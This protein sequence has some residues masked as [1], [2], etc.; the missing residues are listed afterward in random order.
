MYIEIGT[1]T[2]KFN[3]SQQ[4]SSK[5]SVSIFNQTTELES[6]AKSALRYSVHFVADIATNSCV[7]NGIL[8]HLAVTVG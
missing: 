2:G 6:L 4:I 3:G 8:E 7:Q 1:V 5:Y